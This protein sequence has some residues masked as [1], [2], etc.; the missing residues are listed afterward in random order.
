MFFYLKKN[1]TLYIILDNILVLDNNNLF[2]VSDLK[3]MFFKLLFLVPW[4]LLDGNS[5][6]VA[7]EHVVKKIHLLQP[8]YASRT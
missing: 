6:H 2:S 8:K 1:T 3:K 7:H 5:D 4:Y